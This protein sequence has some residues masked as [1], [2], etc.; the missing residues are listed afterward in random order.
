M[1]RQGEG[2]R[3]RIRAEQVLRYL[4]HA[5]QQI[6]PDLAARIDQGVARCEELC[7]PR[8]VWRTFAVEAQEAVGGCEAAGEA[9]PASGAV[10]QVGACQ[11]APASETAGQAVGSQ[12]AS[13]EP[14]ASG[15]QLA[16]RDMPVPLAPHVRLQGTSLVLEGPSICDFLAGATQVALFAC[17]LGASADRE[18]R[19][20]SATDALGQVIFDAAC[21]DLVEWGADEACR[22]I[23]AWGRER[24]LV[25]GDRFSPG[26]ADFPLSVQA[27]FLDVLQ[28]QKRL[29]LTVNE[30]SLLVPTKSVT[31]VVGLYPSA[32]ERGRHL[33]CGVCNLWQNCQMRLR[34]TPC[35]KRG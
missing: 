22:E 29:G 31:C 30:S 1:G 2:R 35:W 5:G 18:L 24:G 13:H 17:T 20:L 11:A 21:T 7:D 8:W 23:A 32:P 26:Y 25:A 14:L 10:G 34:G 33:G 27:H 6:S 15:G 9:A 19:R 4:G 3:G 12:A 28:A 16:S